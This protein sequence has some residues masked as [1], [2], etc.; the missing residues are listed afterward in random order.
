MRLSAQSISLNTRPYRMTDQIAQTWARRL[1]RE[2]QDLSLADQVVFRDKA[3]IHA[4]IVRI[5]AVIAHHEEASGR[6]DDIAR[7]VGR[8]VLHLIEH[9]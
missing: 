2:E 6:H 4:A 5:I 9:I 1:D 8:A 7:I 3:D